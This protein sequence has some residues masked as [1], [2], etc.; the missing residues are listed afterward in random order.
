M[1]IIAW[2]L[3]VALMLG[4]SNV[5]IAESPKG[6]GTV[7]TRFGPVSGV[8]SDEVMGITLFKG[9]PYAAPPVGAL[10]WAE[11]QDPEPWT[12][13]LACDAYADAAVQPPY[14]ET[15]MSPES[16]WG[17]F[18]PDGPPKNSEDCLYLN[19]TTPAV[20]G[21]EQYPVLLW[22][23]GGGLAHGYSYEV[24]FAAEKLAEKGIIVVTSGHRLNVLGF[25]SLPQLSAESAYGASGNYGIM[26]C[27]KS[28]EWIRDNIT[29]F[30]GDPD[31]ITV[32]G[33]SGG[34]AK[35]SATLISDKTDG[36]IAGTINMS[37]FSPFGQYRSPAEAE[38]AGLA[39]LDSIGVSRDA[40]LEELRALDT[41]TLL[42]GELSYSI[43]VD[44]EYITQHPI[45]FYTGAGNLDGID[46]MFGNVFGEAG[47]FEA[48]SAEQLYAKIREEYGDALVDAFDLEGTL[49][50]T[51]E[52]YAFYN[53]YLKT[54]ASMA[55]LRKFA[56]IKA[57]SNADTDSYL[58]TFG[59]ITPGSDIGWHSGEL[60]Y[61]FYSLRDVDWQR[62]WQV[63][64]H[65][66][67]EMASGYWAN[68]TKQGDPNG[69]GLPAWPEG[70]ALSY[71]YIDSVPAVFDEVTSFDAMVMAHVEAEYGLAAA[72]ASGPAL[73]AFDPQAL[74]KDGDTLEH[75]PYTVERLAEN[76]YHIEDGIAA[77]PPGFWVNEDGSPAPDAE[78]NTMNNCA[79]MYM[80]LGADR[81][82]LID[83]SNAI[84]RDSAA[85]ALQ[86]IAY[87]LAGDR[88]L[89]IAITHGHPDHVGMA[90]AFTDSD[91]AIYFPDGD[92]QDYIGEAF[93]L[94][95]ERMTLFTPGEKQF[96][97]G[98]VVLDTFRAQGHTSYS[99]VFVMDTLPV[100]FS[101]DAIGSGSGVWIFNEAGLAEYT[102]GTQAF[103]DYVDAHYSDA[104]RD[105][106]TVYSG[107]AWQYGK[108][109]DGGA[110]HLDWQYIQDMLACMQ[111]LK[112]GAW[113]VEG[114]G[115]TVEHWET[116]I[117][118][119]NCDIIYGTAAISCPYEAAAAYAG[120]E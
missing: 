8:P 92:Y 55:T 79:D 99:T 43:V 2:I 60:W 105:A 85:K 22:F 93:G 64:D 49:P 117:N 84:T 51:E 83:L 66:V 98:G 19:V 32:A 102:N 91:V 72:D 77:Y 111:G 78:G 47:S 20:T 86:D 119:L 90:S 31:R 96:D 63:W 44:G 70:D 42:G 113:L 34:G 23:H 65:I 29:A 103:V 41:E 94:P 118:G 88:A 12:E 9:I 114:S 75:G 6:L 73:A 36:M 46:M 26:D 81:A 67:A 10:R 116:P 108:F 13:V 68:F 76:V 53:I 40:T 57:A 74:A 28:V 39:Y 59:R 3:C 56:E 95:L 109:V 33:Q 21:T 69:E 89:D 120:V 5:A 15:I 24:E 7:E 80:V 61:T 115:V 27:I 52:N 48:E 82:L 58:Y 100:M 35:T 110:D 50:I 17:E 107:H 112:E 1:K 104:E 16:Q 101:G 62:D 106:L 14:T 4:L 25:L 11:P 30:G 87:G 38:E 97:L 18:Y 71:L 54:A 37:G 45:D